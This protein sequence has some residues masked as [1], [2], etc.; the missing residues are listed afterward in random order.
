[1]HDQQRSP[2]G[3]QDTLGHAPQ[4]QPLQAASSVGGQS[5]QVTA[6]QH[7][8]SF[9]VFAGF[10]D[11]EKSTGHISPHRYRA[12][13][14]Q[15]EVCELR[16]LIHPERVKC[17]QTCYA[18]FPVRNAG[19]IP[20]SS[21]DSPSMLSGEAGCSHEA[22]CPM[23]SSLTRVPD[24][25]SPESIERTCHS[26]ITDVERAVTPQSQHCG[27]TCCQ[28]TCAALPACGVTWIMTYCGLTRY[29]G[30]K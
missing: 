11:A 25:P 7:R 15:L 22:M 14:R 12:G 2:G 16:A 24:L 6:P 5:H 8:C 21:C 9:C 19:F 30:D 13:N 23:R 18:S 20:T 28:R 17:A 26:P 10:S 3:S 27:S 4:C 29:P 1:M